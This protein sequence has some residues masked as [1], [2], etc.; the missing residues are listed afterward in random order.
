MRHQNLKNKVNLGFY[1]AKQKREG[2]SNLKI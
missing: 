2:G 1:A